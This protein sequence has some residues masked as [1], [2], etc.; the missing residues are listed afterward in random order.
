MNKSELIHQMA[1][2][3]RDIPKEDAEQAVHQIIEMLAKQLEQGGRCEIRG[4]GSFSV[5][6]RKEHL[7]RNPKTGASVIVPEK[8]VA[9]FKPG[10]PLR[11]QVDTPHQLQ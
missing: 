3:Y 6:K 2:R 1:T 4:F 5:K 11:E 9:H 8:H 7:A 10:K